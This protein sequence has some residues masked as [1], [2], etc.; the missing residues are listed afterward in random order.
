MRLLLP[1]HLHIRHL[2]DRSNLDRWAYKRVLN[3]IYRALADDNFSDYPNTGRRGI[4]DERS[5]GNVL[6]RSERTTHH[7][8]HNLAGDVGHALGHPILEAEHRT[9][10]VDGVTA[11]N[12]AHYAHTQDFQEEGNGRRTL[13]HSA[14]NYEKE[15]HIR[16]AGSCTRIARVHTVLFHNVLV[17][18]VLV[19]S[20]LV[21]VV[22]YVHSLLGSNKTLDSAENSSNLSRSWDGENLEDHGIHAHGQ[23]GCNLDMSAGILDVGSLPF[24]SSLQGNAHLA[25]IYFRKTPGH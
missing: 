2:D 24:P 10:H 12:H 16:H 6:G 14:G 18:S 21:R 15:R 1:D 20:A 17:R 3:D 4:S 25:D 22:V 19:H 23:D 9:Q 8:L 11:D 5:F 13:V 7:T